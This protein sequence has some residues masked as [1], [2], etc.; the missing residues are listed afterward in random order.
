MESSSKRQDSREHITRRGVRRA[1]ISH[2]GE[3]PLEAYANKCGYSDAAPDSTAENYDCEDAAPDSSPNKTTHSLMA[4]RGSLGQRRSI[5]NKYSY[6]DVAP[7]PTKQLYEYE[8]AAPDSPGKKDSRDQ[9]VVKKPTNGGRLSSISYSG[10]HQ[11]E[12]ESLVILSGSNH[13]KSPVKTKRRSSI[14]YF[15][16][17]VDQVD[18]ELENGSFH[19]PRQNDTPKVKKLDNGSLHSPR[20]SGKTKTKNKEL[21]NGSFHSPRQKSK[22]K[23]KKLENGSFHSPRQSGKT[24]AKNKEIGD[25]SF[26]SPR[27][28]DK[29]KVKKLENGSFHSRRQ[30]GK[31]K[32]KN[33]EIEQGSFHSPRQDDKPNVNKLE[34]DSFHSPR[35]NKV[36]ELKNESFQLPRQSGKTKENVPYLNI[37]SHGKFSKDVEKIE[38]SYVVDYLDQVDK[39]LESGSFHTRR[40]S[41]GFDNS[42]VELPKQSSKTQKP[43]EPPHKKEVKCPPNNYIGIWT[44]YYPTALQHKEATHWCPG[45]VK[46]ESF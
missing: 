22:S 12:T 42:N 26:H 35:Q 39:E 24:K 41:I 5:D 33:K 23:V 30:F 7:D 38:D 45:V 40:R 4:R 17:Y 28:H 19:S 37:S 13:M 34:N 9:N 16:D 32:A 31:T 14:D 36:K 46:V 25:G 6:E 20:H 27:R 2:L 1:S 44:F 8:D 15:I 29:P 18:K 11:P 10:E 3:L 21:E 43:E